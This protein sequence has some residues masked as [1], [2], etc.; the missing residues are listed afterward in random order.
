M[1]T[2]TFEMGIMILKKNIKDINDT[3]K[4][5]RSLLGDEMIKNY[6]IIDQM[7]KINN[8]KELKE[9]TKK[10]IHESTKN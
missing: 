9:L 8:M 3:N 2:N 4:K 10:L 1:K 6:D 7:S 5:L